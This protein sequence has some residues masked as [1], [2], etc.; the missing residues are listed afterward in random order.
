MCGFKNY[1][2][3]I[4]LPGVTAI[5]RRSGT[6]LCTR[7]AV[8]ARVG[9]LLYLGYTQ[10]KDINSARMVYSAVR[11]TERKA[12]TPMKGHGSGVCLGDNPPTLSERRG[13]FVGGD[14]R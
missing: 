13:N 5:P 6:P 9:A 4:A 3:A 14:R 12:A 1:D 2:P 11:F 8:P 10:R 7:I